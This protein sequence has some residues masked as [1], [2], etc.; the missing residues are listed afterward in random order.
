MPKIAILS[1]GESAE[2]E[3]ALLSSQFIKAQAKRFFEVMVF[4]FPSDFD[5]FIK[6]RSGFNL[7]IPVFHGRGGEDGQ[8]QG[9]L[10]TLKVP[11]L[12]SGIS[13]HSLAMDK[14]LT[15]IIARDL[16]IKQ[17]KAKVILCNQ[18]IKFIKKVVVKPYDNGSSI[19]VSI[20]NSQKELDRGLRQVWQY[21]KKALVEEYLAG[22]EYTVAVVDFRGKLISLPVIWIKPI[23]GDFFDY[24][25]KYT[26]S[27]A[28]E[29]CPAPISKAVAFEL[30]R[31]ALKI[32]QQFGLKHMSRSD[33]IVKNGQPYFLEVNT[34]PG[35]TKNSLVPKAVKA[36]KLDFGLLLKEWIEAELKKNVR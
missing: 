36:A 19:G 22:K 12:F 27:G 4:D 20:V 7:A 8:I 17:P 23:K 11:Y 30:Q 9:F 34:I 31:I 13:G 2:R 10:E 18:K 29:I 25:S 14:A 28:E 5:K 1:G 32:H 6:A 21:S 15:K 33:F 16:K 3:I 26:D 24:Q 35:L